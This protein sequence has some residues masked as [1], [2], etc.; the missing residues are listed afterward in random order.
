M[1]RS[2][3]SR[4][5]HRLYADLVADSLTEIVYDA[6]LADLSY[7]FIRHD[8]GISVILHGYN[9]KL[10]VL[11]KTVFERAR[12]LVV[13]EERLHVVKSAVRYFLLQS[14]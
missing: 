11:A 7:Q 10:H 8:L 12:N 3:S 5:T 13:T 14:C 4:P 2:I 1:L 9:D 6:D